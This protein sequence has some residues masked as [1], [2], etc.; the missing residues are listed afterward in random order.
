MIHEIS[1]YMNEIVKEADPNA[2]IDLNIMLEDARH[3]VARE[4]QSVQRHLTATLSVQGFMIA[5]L[6]VLLPLQKTLQS[7]SLEKIRQLAPYAI[8]LIGLAVGIGAFVGVLAARIALGRAI[9]RWKDAKAKSATYRSDPYGGDILHKAG[10]LSAYL[11]VTLIP[12]FWIA[13]LI[14]LLR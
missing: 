2:S 12:L 7:A 5:A 4:D 9:R 14:I 6:M 11:I 13:I 3:D 1:I 8:S 10:G